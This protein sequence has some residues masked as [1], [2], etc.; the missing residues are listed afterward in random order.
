MRRVI[1]SFPFSSEFFKNLDSTYTFDQYFI[2]RFVKLKTP[3][4]FEFYQQPIDWSKSETLSDRL[5][6]DE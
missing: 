1:L 6:Q 3:P 2:D 5:P 4:K